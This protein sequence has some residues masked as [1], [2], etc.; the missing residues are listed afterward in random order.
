M[1]NLRNGCLD[2]LNKSHEGADGSSKRDPVNVKTSVKNVLPV[3]TAPF[4]P[5]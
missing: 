2:G 1:K 4:R 5:S 3:G